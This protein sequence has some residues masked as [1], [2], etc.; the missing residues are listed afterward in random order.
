[1]STTMPMTK[2]EQ[3][4]CVISFSFKQKKNSEEEEEE[5]RRRKMKKKKC[6]I[7]YFELI[8]CF[9]LRRTTKNYT[10]FNFGTKRNNNKIIPQNF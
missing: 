5:R 8:S 10:K 3:K 1:M 2:A 9:G 7:N 6:N 4:L